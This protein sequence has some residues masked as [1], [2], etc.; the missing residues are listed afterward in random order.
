MSVVHPQSPRLYSSVVATPPA[1]PRKEEPIIKDS[2]SDDEM[3]ALEHKPAGSGV[4][5]DVSE[6]QLNQRRYS[7]SEKLARKAVS[8]LGMIRITDVARITMKSKN[9][10]IHINSPDV[11]KS[12]DSDSYVAFGEA[13]FDDLST[14]AQMRAAEQFMAAKPFDTTQQSVPEEEEDEVEED[15]SGVKDDEITLVMQQVSH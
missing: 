2:D 4:P 8:K 11:Y 3:P 5:T 7:K 15:E 12:H 10:M 1:S 9:M 14:L 13:K 6:E